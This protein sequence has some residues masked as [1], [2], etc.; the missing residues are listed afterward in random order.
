VNHKSLAHYEILDLLGKGG[1]GE[2]YRARDGKLGREVAIKILPAEMSADPERV[3]RFEREARTLASLQHPNI[4]SIYGFEEEAGSRFLVMELVKGEDLGSRMAAGRIPIKETIRIARQIATGLEAAHE[5]GIVHRDLKPANIMLN[6]A[7]E[8]KILDFG[9]ARAWYGD[10]SDGE[11]LENSPT[12]T[13]AMTRAGVILGTAAYMSPEQARGR[14]VDRRAD[15]WAFGVILWE[16]VTGQRLFEGETVSDTIAGVLRAEPDWELLPVDEAP[17]LCRLI[18]RCLVRDPQQRLRDIGEARILLQDGGGESAIIS[19]P[20]G[21]RALSD[22]EAASSGLRWPIAALIGVVALALGAVIGWRFLSTTPEPLLLHTMIP[23]PENGEF[24]MAGG[25]PGPAVLSPDG[26]M[27]AFSASGE[28][29]IVHLYLR[30]LDSGEAVMLSGTDDAAY[31]FWSP[32]SKYIAFFSM[33]DAK[34]RKMAVSGGPPVTLCRADNGK[35][36]SWNEDGVIIFAP[37]AGTTIHRVASIGGEPEPITT[38]ESGDDSHRHP[39]FLPNGRDFIFTVRRDE[40]LFEIRMGSLDGRRPIHITESECQ[41]EYASGYL[42]TASEGVL[43]ATAFD[44][45]TGELSGGSTPLVEQLLVAGGGAGV[46]SYSVLPSGMMLFQ[47]GSAE[48]DRV[49]SWGDLETQRSVQ[50]GSSGLIFCPRISPDGSRCV[51]E[52]Q[53]EAPLGRDLWMVDL[54]SGQ[55]TRFTFEQGDEVAACW[56]PDGSTIVYT[57]REGGTN[58]IMERPVEGTG[59]AS[60]LYESPDRL[61]TDSVHPDG[62]GVLFTRDLP[63]TTMMWNLE[64]LAFDGGEEPSIILPDEGYGG[65]YSPNG[66]WIAYGGFTADRWEVFVMPASGGPRKWQI[67]TSGAVW[68]QW[69][70]D[71]RRLFV[72][73]FGS[74]A[75]ACEVET[76]GSSFQFGTLQELMSVDDLIPGGVPF[77]VHP[78]GKRIV[79]AGPDPSVDQ[80]RVSPIHFVTD[81]R[82]ALAR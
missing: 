12:I 19:M 30:H 34:L 81:W 33:A 16:M 72:Q 82:R 63:D 51:V 24:D 9:L 79:Q 58:R 41:A 39:R 52:I 71:G 8:A 50:I 44:P 7:G 29:G 26:S 55:R 10:E 74:M 3:A 53:G 65:R 75:A 36:G 5:R 40:G 1:M 2:V 31:P 43:F 57:S 32:D 69:Q 20:A 66:R 25:S 15:I 70:P 13:A 56:T 17:H 38:L 76:G 80:D 21:G 46:G 37:T 60:T 27:V 49:L 68:P 23:A 18:E 35:G 4:A 73:S 42:F 45:A 48:T 28:D 61:T 47:T 62:H 67:T 77:D 54:Q 6:E 78:D 59:G 64:F 22:R 11:A 14:K